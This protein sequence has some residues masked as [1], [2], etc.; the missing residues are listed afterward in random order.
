MGGVEACGQAA[1]AERGER[2]PR[3]HEATRFRTF[4]H[5]ERVERKEGEGGYGEL[6]AP[7]ARGGRWT[8]LRSG[9][10]WRVRDECSTARILAGSFGKE[11]HVFTL[12]EWCKIGTDLHRSFGKKQR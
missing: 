9:E 3:R 7:C 8:G 5:K 6:L 11:L 2:S 12:L 4:N 1:V 10:L